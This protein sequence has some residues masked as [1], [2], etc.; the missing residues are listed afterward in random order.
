[1]KFYKI[2]VLILTVLFFTNC[3]Q[4]ITIKKNKFTSINPVTYTD[5][6]YKS[7]RDTVFV[8]TYSGKIYELINNKENR[9]QIASLDD[10][11]YSLV[12]NAQSDELYAATLNSGVVIINA[13]TGA[14]TGTLPIQQ[15]WASQ[16]CYNEQ[17]GLLGTFDYKG[18][19]YIWDLKNDYKLLETPTELQQMRPKY[20]ADNGDIYFDGKSKIIRW[21]YKTNDMASLNS[22]GHI[23]D[24]DAEKNVV[25]IGGKEFAFYNAEVDSV[26]Y[27]EKHP[28]WPIHISGKDRKDSIVNVPLSLEVLSGLASPKF[29][30][31]YGLD[32]SIRKWNKSS[33]SL[34]A[35]Y[36]KHKGS[37]SGMTMNSDQNQ[38][39][40]I[41]LLGNIQFWEL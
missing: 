29:I 31:T 22:S 7:N 15:T 38:L 16:L 12:Y 23:A 8:S 40:T 37:I 13:S 18:N 26:L 39:V 27:K 36:T 35:T 11:I 25:L 21:N 9:K 10:E 20:I 28:D 14:V 19:H 17:S 1:M 6:L 33:G 30:Y 3:E 34:A 5:V 2:T 4:K 32:K 41:D 24:V